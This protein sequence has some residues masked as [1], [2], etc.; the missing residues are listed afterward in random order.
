MENFVLQSGRADRAYWVATLKRIAEWAARKAW[1][2]AFTPI[3]HAE[4]EGA[5]GPGRN[6]P[7]LPFLLHHLSGR[8]AE[9]DNHLRQSFYHSVPGC[10]Y[11]DYQIE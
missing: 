1:G 7:V 4:D 2:G 9:S 8:C 5:H 6:L 3:D 10:V 11:N